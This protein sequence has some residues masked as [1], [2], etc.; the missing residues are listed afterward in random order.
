MDSKFNRVAL[1]SNANLRPKFSRKELGLAGFPRLTLLSRSKGK[2]YISERIGGEV[3]DNL[4]GWLQRQWNEKGIEEVVIENGMMRNSVHDF[5]AKF[6]DRIYAIPGA[7][8]TP[9]H[10]WT[11]ERVYFAIEFCESAVQPVSDAILEYMNAETGFIKSL[12]FMGEYNGKIPF[13]LNRYFALGGGMESFKVLKTRWILTDQEAKNE[14]Q[15]I[16]S[17]S[18]NF[19]PKCYEDSTTSR[20]LFSGSENSFKGDASYTPVCPDGC[21]GELEVNSEFFPSFYHN[22]ILSQI[23]PLFYYAV[24]EKGS[25]TNSFILPEEMLSVLIG[26][27]KAHFDSETRRHHFNFILSVENIKDTLMTPSPD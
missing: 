9:V 2:W 25:V 23:G 5:N 1:I 6:M 14:V 19:Y 18:G 8:V 17:N 15:G 24:S 26:H 12:D 21:C 22:I 27:I 7:R 4:L 13:I 3:T 11:G 16:F 10:I 20:L